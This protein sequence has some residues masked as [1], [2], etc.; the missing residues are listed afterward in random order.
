MRNNI[1]ASALTDILLN[2]AS[3]NPSGAVHLV[4]P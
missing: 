2:S 1:V 4:L 3:G